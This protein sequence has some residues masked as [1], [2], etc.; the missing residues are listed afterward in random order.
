MASTVQANQRAPAGN[1]LLLAGDQRDVADAF[2]R[3]HAIVV[4]AREQPQRETD[5]AARVSEHALHRQV[6]LA[7]IGR[8]EH[9][10]DPRGEAKHA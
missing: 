2:L 8:P 9:R 3:D 1:D 5:H 4:L 7:G 10:F 6:R